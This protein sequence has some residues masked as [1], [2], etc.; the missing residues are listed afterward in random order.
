MK[1]ILLTLVVAV[2]GAF[3]CNA[4]LLW[5]ITG[6]G[7]EKP[8]YLFGT[9]HVAPITVL[10]SVPGLNSALASADK[11]YGELIMSESNTPAAQQVMLG[12]AMAPQDSTLT[13]VLS[14]A[15]IDSL[16][17]VLKANM[18]PMAGANQFAPLKPAMLSTVLAMVQ[19][20]KVFPTF[21][22]NKQLDTE[23]QNRGAAAGKEIG[24]FE[25]LEDQCKAM[26]GTPIIDQANELMELIRNDEKS[27]STALK[28]ANAY[29]A[30]DLNK[31]LAI[32][33]EPGNGGNGEEWT[34]RMINKR[35][36]NWV[37]IMV[38]LLPTASVFIAVG[39]GH[40]PGEKGL[41]NLLKKE[42][43]NVTPV[44]E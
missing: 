41:I 9:H 33:E 44:E 16:D 27:A 29:L 18:G 24:S 6:N 30:G 15:Q 22:P 19:S 4:Q 11:V 42:G 28:L 14:P 34:E 38:G 36:A 8:S 25:T 20:Q 23:V 12:Y 7:L 43:Y 10:D 17:K 26:F 39:A 5:K 13:A 2:A 40:L 1:K 31:M 21:D 35:N 3:G 32:M 37:R